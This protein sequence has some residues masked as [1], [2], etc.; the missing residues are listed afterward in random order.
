[1]PIGPGD[2]V[3]QEAVPVADVALG[4]PFGEQELDRL[5][6]DLVAGVAERGLGLGIDVDDHALVVD[7]DDRRWARPR[8]RPGTAA[9]SRQGRVRPPCGP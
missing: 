5:A 6:D 8:G 2:R 3:G 4:D 7:R 9:R 1:M